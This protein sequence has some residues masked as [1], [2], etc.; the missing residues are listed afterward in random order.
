MHVQ[1]RR[2]LRRMRPRR[3]RRPTMK[4]EPLPLELEDRAGADQV[5]TPPATDTRGTDRRRYWCECC[6]WTTSPTDATRRHGRC[7]ECHLACPA[8]SR[9]RAGY[10]PAAHRAA[11][12]ERARRA[13]RARGPRRPGG[14]TV[15]PFDTRHA[16]ADGI[17][18]DPTSDTY[19]AAG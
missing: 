10:T 11:E 9:C 19:G 3:M 14:V 2:I 18:T 5:T 6:G 17:G 13:A 1:Q 12:L 7:A 8:S 4:H 16:P 15:D